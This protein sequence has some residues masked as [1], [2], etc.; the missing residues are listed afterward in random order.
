MQFLFYNHQFFPHKVWIK[1]MCVC[2]FIRKCFSLV[3]YG[4][5]YIYKISTFLCRIDRTKSFRSSFFF[6]SIVLWFVKQLIFFQ[7]Y[8]WNCIHSTVN[9]DLIICHEFQ[10]TTFGLHMNWRFDIL[11]TSLGVAPCNAPPFGRKVGLIKLLSPG[12]VTF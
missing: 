11:N 10:K 7:L 8:S 5:Y 6:F 12:E 1:I 2:V 9:T 3:N 4:C